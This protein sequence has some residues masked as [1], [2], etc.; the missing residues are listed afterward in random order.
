MFCLDDYWIFSFDGIQIFWTQARFVEYCS[1]Y[2][3]Y[4]ANVSVLEKGS[5]PELSPHKDDQKQ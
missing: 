2:R 1:F 5:E 3:I 4:G